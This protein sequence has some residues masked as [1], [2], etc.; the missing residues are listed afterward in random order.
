MEP[1]H[2]AAKPKQVEQQKFSFE[3]PKFN[4][5]QN[6]FDDIDML[7]DKY[8]MDNFILHFANVVEK[9]I[10]MRAAIKIYNLYLKRF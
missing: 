8:G 10:T 5:I 4:V 2:R 9:R 1:I 3:K 7:L 6:L